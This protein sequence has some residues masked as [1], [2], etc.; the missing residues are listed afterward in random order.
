METK[1][2]NKT[3][4]LLI[5][6]IREEKGL[7]QAELA[8]LMNINPQNVSSYERGERCPSLFWITRLCKA[9]QINPK[10]FFNRFYDLLN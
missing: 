8:A 7:T 10:D 9:I 3:L 5:K 4:G 6:T 1:D 2:F